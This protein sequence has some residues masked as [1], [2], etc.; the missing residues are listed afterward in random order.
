M[1]KF[2]NLSQNELLIIHGGSE[3]SYTLGYNIGYFLGAMT[4]NAV[5]A[6]VAF[7]DGVK[8]GVQAIKDLKS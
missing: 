5:N 8:E 1:K 7:A 6:M 2:E 4:S 3:E